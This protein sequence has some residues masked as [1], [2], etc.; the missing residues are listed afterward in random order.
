MHGPLELK[1]VAG[2][3]RTTQYTRYFWAASRFAATSTGL[4]SSHCRRRL[5]TPIRRHRAKKPCKSAS[6]DASYNSHLDKLIGPGDKQRPGRRSGFWGRRRL[7]DEETPADTLAAV[8]AAAKPQ[9]LPILTTHNSGWNLLRIAARL[10]RGLGLRGCP[11]MEVAMSSRP[12]RFIHASDFHL[13]RPLM[14]VTEVPDHLRELFL[15]APYTAAR[16]VFEAALVEDVKFVVLSGGMVVPAASGPRGPLFLAEQLRDSPSGGL[17]SIGRVRRSTCPR[18]GRRRCGC[19][20]TFTSFR[21]GGSRNC[22]CK[23]RAG[24]S[25]RARDQLRRAAAVAADRFPARC[26][27]VVHDRRRPRRGRR[28]GIHYCVGAAHSQPLW[29]GRARS[30]HAPERPAGGPLL[31]HSARPAAGGERHSRLY[32]RASRRAAADA[33][34]SDSDRCGA[35]DGERL[36]VDEATTA[37]DLNR[38]FASGC[39]RFWKRCRRRPC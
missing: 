26:R 8:P 33:D 32:A 19:R 9:C 5:L 22:W 23:G 3:S 1:A 25:A 10:W 7:A 14:G 30:Q 29:L 35:L 27:R 24:P 11:V 37:E 12:F 31:R 18:F 36:S 34:Q 2:T 39:T 15:E 21:G 38:G 20:K 16:R 13:E 28:G 6:G 4:I 17:P